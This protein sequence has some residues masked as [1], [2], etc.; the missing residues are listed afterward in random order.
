V[1]AVAPIPTLHGPGLGIQ[2]IGLVLTIKPVSPIFVLK[3][4]YA[5][6]SINS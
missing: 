5:C 4:T 1:R 3:Q 2:V 6:L